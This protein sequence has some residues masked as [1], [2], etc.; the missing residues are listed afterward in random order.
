MFTI[1]ESKKSKGFKS[2]KENIAVIENA[3]KERFDQNL[4]LAGY[5]GKNI[6]L[7]GNFS[8]R[9]FKPAG[10]NTERSYIVLEAVYFDDKP[11]TGKVGTLALSA[12]KAS[13]K[14]S[15]DENL[16]SVVADF[17]ELS[18]RDALNKLLEDKT[19]LKCEGELTVLRPEFYQENGQNKVR[20]DETKTKKGYKYSVQTL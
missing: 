3:R 2:V 6:V 18:E 19:Y 8:E 20:Y 1:E 16:Q 5:N 7:T 13:V 17:A 9:K 4:A 12:L 15:I 11:E 10:S 14:P